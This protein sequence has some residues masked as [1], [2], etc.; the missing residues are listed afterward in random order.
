MAGRSLDD[1][2]FYMKYQKGRIMVPSEFDDAGDDTLFDRV[3]SPEAFYYVDQHEL[4]VDSLKRRVEHL[5]IGEEVPEFFGDVLSHDDYFELADYYVYRDEKFDQVID[6]FNR[7]KRRVAKKRQQKW[8]NDRR[9]KE[10]LNLH[11]KRMKY[12]LKQ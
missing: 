4:Y 11:N 2:I 12:L 5:M 7:V 3:E 6:L 1:L 10:R 9:M 8:E